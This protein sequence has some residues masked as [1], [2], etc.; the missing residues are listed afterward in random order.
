MP[1]ININSIMNK[2]KAYS[3]SDI[4]KS[5]MAKF[6]SERRDE[7]HGKLASGD[8]IVTEQ[9]M[10]HAAEELIKILQETASQKGLPESVKEHFDSLYHNSPI[11]YDKSGTKYKVDVRFKDDLSRMSLQITS[12]KNKGSRTGEGIK[13][14]VSLFDTGYDA[15][16][17]VYGSWDGHV[18]DTIA[19]LPHRD[20]LNFMG[21]A[22]DSFNRE[23]GK[24]YNV[25]AYISS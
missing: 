25:F 5:R 17:R 2:V 7:G 24:L 21:E 19:S 10:I 1:N 13:D 3:K 4:G 11:P 20:G 14:I 6:I 12:G 16:K 18:N 15:E 23:Y 8:H 22:I 9:D